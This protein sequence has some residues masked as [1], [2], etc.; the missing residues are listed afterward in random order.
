MF[1]KAA[2][3]GVSHKQFVNDCKKN[4]ILIMGI[5]HRI[6]IN[7]NPDKRVDLIRDYALAK[8]GTTMVLDSALCVEKVTTAHPERGWLHRAAFCRH[9]P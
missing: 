9:A 6:K 1:T 2:D 5:G 4:N 7:A 3:A 8:V